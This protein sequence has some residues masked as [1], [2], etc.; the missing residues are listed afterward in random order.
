MLREQTFSTVCDLVPCR[1]PICYALCRNANT[2][3]EAP[4]VENGDGTGV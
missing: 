3:D 4:L 2:S 1:D